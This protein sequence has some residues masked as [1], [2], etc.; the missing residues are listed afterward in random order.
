[1]IL[2]SI[3]RIKAHLMRKMCYIFYAV[4]TYW[5]TVLIWLSKLCLTAS[6]VFC[7]FGVRRMWKG[8]PELLLMFL[9]KSLFEYVLFAGCPSNVD[10]DHN[11]FAFSECLKCVSRAV[12]NMQNL[13][14]FNQ[15]LN[16][17]FFRSQDNLFHHLPLFHCERILGAPEQYFC[18]TKTK[19]S[20]NFPGAA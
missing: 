19:N 15:F 16:Y 13:S 14:L 12:R 3:R 5:R 20:L 2:G 6:L 9:G 1:M 10:S 18:L 17:L 8:F 4:P 7:S 11:F